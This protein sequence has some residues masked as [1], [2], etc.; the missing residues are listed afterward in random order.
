M[1]S[2]PSGGESADAG[3]RRTEKRFESGLHFSRVLRIFTV[4]VQFAGK[5]QSARSE[6]S[7]KVI[8]RDGT[9][10]KLLPSDPIT[11]VSSK[12]E[13]IPIY[14]ADGAA[15]GFRSLEAAKRLLAGGFVKPSC[16]RK[17]HL[18][19]IWLLREDGGNPVETHARAGT[20]YSF[21]EKLDH[22]RCWKFRRLDR[23]EE[24]QS[25]GRH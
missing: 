3:Y 10:H 25:Y 23:E 15:L 7:P 4:K 22:G 21:L 11:E 12:R 13:Q 14:A 18:K 2:D 1:P 16:G 5:A 6:E 17:G 19:A 24:E 20:R 9:L 8:P